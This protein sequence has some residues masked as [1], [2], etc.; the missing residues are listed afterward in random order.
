M[1][2][3]GWETE[4]REDEKEEKDGR[5]HGQGGAEEG[6]AESLLTGETPSPSSA[7]K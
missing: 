6:Q 5:G 1:R 7:T 4:M 3:Q 2:L